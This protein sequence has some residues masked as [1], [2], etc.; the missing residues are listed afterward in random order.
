MFAQTS[1]LILVSKGS[2]EVQDMK[3]AYHEGTLALHMIWS[4]VIIT[5]NAGPHLSVQT[6]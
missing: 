6:L 3:P 2:N 1:N 5:C 4:T